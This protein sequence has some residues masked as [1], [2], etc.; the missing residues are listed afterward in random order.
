MM[1]GNETVWSVLP[2][3]IL[4]GLVMTLIE[5]VFGAGKKSKEKK[6]CR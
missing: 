4:L 3:V 6:Q 5:M 2:I 1:L